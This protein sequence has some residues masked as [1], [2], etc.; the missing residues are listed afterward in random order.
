[1]TVMNTCNR[2]GTNCLFARRICLIAVSLILLVLLSA[3]S[4]TPA[5]ITKYMDLGEK[6]LV[7]MN[8]EEALVAYEKVIE[9]DPKN[10]DAY[11]GIARAYEGLNDFAKAAET[12]KKGKE[13]SIGTNAPSQEQKQKLLSWYDRLADEALENG[14]EDTALSCYSLIL[15]LDPDNQDASEKI[16]EYQ[17]RKEAAERADEL[18]QEMEEQLAGEDYEAIYDLIESEQFQELTDMMD[19]LGDEDSMILDTENGKT[20]IYRVESQYGSFMLYYGDYNGEIREGNGV[21]IGSSGDSYYCAIGSWSG[22]KPNGPQTVRE[23]YPSRGSI[24][25]R[26]IIGTAADG[27]WNGTVDWGFITDTGKL[28]YI[29]DFTNGHWNKVRRTS[30]SDGSDGWDVS[31]SS[32]GDNDTDMAISED[33]IDEIRGIIGFASGEK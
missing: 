3:C 13:A 20:G 33:E 1:M 9:L 28:G 4:S 31:R 23:C 32:Y 6:Y 7:E 8:Y 5:Q 10:F 2:S 27:L 14:D 25:K 15:E 12:L 26:E 18:S 16:E 22:D 19:Q 21:W 29:A 11:E 17:R 24:V 30:M